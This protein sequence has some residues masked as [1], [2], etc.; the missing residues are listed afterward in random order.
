M[1]KELEKPYVIAEISQNHDGSLGQAH[2]FIDAVAD[3]GVSAVKFQTHIASQESTPLEPFRV[4]FSFEDQT[5]YDYWERMEFT[6]EQWAGLKKHADDR[7]IDFLSSPFSM[8]A[9]ELLDKIGVP[10]MKF[11][12]GE[13]FNESLLDAAIATGKP[14]LL[15]S[16]LSTWEDL[17]KHVYKVR[18]NGNETVIFQCVTAYPSLPE[19]IDIGLITQ[20]RERYEDCVIGISDHS[21]T[22]YPC[23]AAMTLGA[24]VAEVHVT[25]SP[26]M[27]G[28]DVKASVSLDDLKRIV[29]GA[30]SITAMK[31]ARTDFSKRD[32]DRENLK[33]MFSKSIFYNRNLEPGHVLVASDLAAKKPN[34]GIPENRKAELIGKT[35]TKAVSV[36][37][38]VRLEDLK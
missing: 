7:G 35:L 27:F 8:K 30:V 3:Q 33:Q 4:P 32:V 10:A 21:A 12:A 22:I 31:N 37:E 14:I 34:I 13:I 20:M 36:D 19:Q 6:S 23:L 5:R 17:D 16:G 2:A 9:L 29:D 28:P 38:P 25:M 11:G 26:Y 24:M 1:F 15:S 18:K